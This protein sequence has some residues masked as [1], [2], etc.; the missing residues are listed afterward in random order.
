MSAKT[1]LFAELKAA[2]KRANQRMLRLERAG[3]ISPAYAVAL[4]DM[5][6]ILNRPGDS[7]FKYNKSMSYNDMQRELRYTNKFLRSVSS[8]RSGMKQI[9]KRRAKTLK[10]RFGVATDNLSN[11]YRVLSGGAYKR[12]AELLPSA[13]VVSTVNDAL[14]M[15]KTSDDINAGLDRFLLDEKDEFLLDALREDLDLDDPDDPFEDDYE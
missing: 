11:L 14:E 1:D 9:A 7:R 5:R 10:S 2:T 12:A 6:E 3:E 13:M 15:G 8:T 4:N